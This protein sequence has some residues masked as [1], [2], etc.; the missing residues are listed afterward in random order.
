[1]ILDA[2]QS[3]YMGVQSFYM[4]AQ[5]NYIAV[6]DQDIAP[7]APRT[8]TSERRRRALAPPAETH[9]RRWGNQ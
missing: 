6:L 5:S 4:A 7:C 8:G 1:M 3:F 2:A 9:E